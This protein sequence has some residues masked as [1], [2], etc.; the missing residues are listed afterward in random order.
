MPEAIRTLLEED[1]ECDF[2]LD[3][4][5]GLTDLDRQ[6]FATLVETD[7]PLTV[8]ELA[9]RVER[10]RT[11]AYRSVQRLLDADLVAQEKVS[12]EGSSYY[13]VYEPRDPDEIADQMQRE[14]NDYYAKM[15]QLIAEFREKFGEKQG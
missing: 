9:E 2:L 3:C 15:G 8:D 6:C 10:D 11:T 4:F 1:V 13:H 7:G 5:H 12:G 14:L